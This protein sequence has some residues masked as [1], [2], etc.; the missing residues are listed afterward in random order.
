MTIFGYAVL[1]SW[2]ITRYAARTALFTSKL[3]VDEIHLELAV[4]L[5]TYK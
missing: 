3:N 2:T 5:Y 1:V 4:G